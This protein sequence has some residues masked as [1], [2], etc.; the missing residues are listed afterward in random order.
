MIILFSVI[1]IG[2]WLI[3]MDL[4]N[5]GDTQLKI[6]SFVTFFKDN[7]LL[8]RI[9]YCVLLPV[10]TYL[11]PSVKR[12]KNTNPEDKSF[13]L[14]MAGLLTLIVVYGYETEYYYYNII[15]PIIFVLHITITARAMLVTSDV[16]GG[17]SNVTKTPLGKVNLEETFALNTDKGLLRIHNPYQGII[18]E[19]AAGGGKSVFLIEPTQH[20][21]IMNGYAAMIYD[22]KGKP[23][24]LGLTAYNTIQEAK[25]QGKTPAEFAIINFTMLEISARTNPISPRYIEDF[26]FCQETIDVFMKSVN[27]SWIEKTDFW[28]D[29]AILYVQCITWRL[30]KNPTLHKY[31]TLPHV[32]SLVLSNFNYVLKW[33]LEDREIEKL[34]Q[35]IA[36]AFQN[37]ATQQLAGQVASAQSVLA[38]MLDPSLFW[39]LSPKDDEMFD[40][41]ISNK[42]NPKILSLSNDT[43]KEVALS[44]VISVIMAVIKQKINQKGKNPC[45]FQVDELPTCYI[46]D[47]D[48]L[49]ATAR[50]NKVITSVA[51]QGREQLIKTYGE[52]VANNILVN[53]SNVFVGTTT[54]MKTAEY[55]CKMVG[56]NDVH[57]TSYSTS[58]ESVS[59]SDSLQLQDVLQPRDVM[60]QK[61][62]EFTGK[63]SGG[64]PN[65]VKNI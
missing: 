45:L 36:V 61:P 29:S 32:I 54:S 22:Y 24:E 23:P 38:K 53:L 48:K 55:V 37:D 44:P 34:M 47:L 12:L 51:L 42:D 63:I 9:F 26:L 60:A 28:S 56:K 59:T 52:K 27:P 14:L 46:K 40:L 3:T 17:V 57:K 33:L 41:D 16:L 21:A 39:V 15:Y 31:C 10:L 6:G 20:Q 7:K 30:A 8:I 65:L 4:I 58:S 5:F 49:P 25:Y 1:I 64:E 62:G 35:P 2:D 19:S 11:V 43:Q 13:Y 50:S 18:I